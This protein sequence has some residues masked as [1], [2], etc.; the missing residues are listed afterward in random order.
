MCGPF[1]SVKHHVGL[2]AAVMRRDDCS[3]VMCLE[4]YA[5]TNGLSAFVLADICLDSLAAWHFAFRECSKGAAAVLC[6]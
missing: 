5:G 2:D 3:F 1:C 6:A 4:M